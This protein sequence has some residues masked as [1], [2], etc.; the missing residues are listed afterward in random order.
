MDVNYN[1]GNSIR[2]QGKYFH[3]EGIQ[4]L[5]QEPREGVG[6]PPLDILQTGLEKHPSV[7]GPPLSPGLGWRPLDTLLSVNYSN[8]A[9]QGSL[10]T[11]Q[12]HKNDRR[13]LL[14][15]ITFRL[16]Q[17]S[18]TN[19]VLETTALRPCLKGNLLS[20]CHSLHGLQFPTENVLSAMVRAGIVPL[21]TPAEQGKIPAR[22][23]H[24]QHLTHSSPLST[25]S[26][27]WGLWLSSV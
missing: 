25:S 17:A 5:E 9:C 18:Y 10:Q 7:T 22:R 8:T 2:Y 26:Q 11:L 21:G 24:H 23:N 20:Q 27:P 4:L 19:T 3:P 13:V 6:S 15:R 12:C 1:T 16:L 14:L